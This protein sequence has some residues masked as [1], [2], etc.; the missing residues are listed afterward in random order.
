MDE[1]ECGTYLTRLW[2]TMPALHHAS[3]L[4]LAEQRRRNARALCFV[5]CLH[6]RPNLSRDARQRLLEH[7]RGQFDMGAFDRH[8]RRLWARW[9]PS[10]AQKPLSRL[11]AFGHRLTERLT[12]KHPVCST[13]KVQ[14]AGSSVE[15]WAMQQNT[16]PTLVLR[17][18]ASHLPTFVLDSLG[19]LTKEVIHGE[20]TSIASGAA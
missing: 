11:L 4:P 9:E 15:V 14:S 12:E 8:R 5:P 16:R 3:L 1:V 20:W 10:P 13:W 7:I 2:D 19:P 17:A 6:V 18:N